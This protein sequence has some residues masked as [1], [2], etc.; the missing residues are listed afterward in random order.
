MFDIKTI[1]NDLIFRDVYDLASQGITLPDFPQGISKVIIKK[2][3]AEPLY[4]RIDNKR[5]KIVCEDEIGNILV[6][7][8][9]IKNGISNNLLKF[10]CEASGKEPLGEFKLKQLEGLKIKATVAHYFNDNGLGYANIVFC[11]PATE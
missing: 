2:C 5:V 3:T 10:I 4:G 1:D 9:I 8:F 6:V 11:E 7:V